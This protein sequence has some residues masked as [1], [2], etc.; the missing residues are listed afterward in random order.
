MKP[1]TLPPRW[2]HLVRLFLPAGII[3]A[4][5]FSLPVVHVYGQVATPAIEAENAAEERPDSPKLD[6]IGEK[7]KQE[8]NTSPKID[9]AKADEYELMKMF[10]D[11]LDEVQRN[12]VEPISRREL[13]EA[14]IEG[15]LAKLDVYSDYIAPEDI[16]DFRKDVESEFGGIGIQV[17]L[18]DGQ[19]TVVRPLNGTP[20][21]RAGLRSGDRIEEVNGTSTIGL[22]LDEAVKLMK[23][24]IGTSVL[25]KVRHRDGSVESLSIKR[26]NILVET[27]ISHARN[28]DGTWDFMFDK[29]DKIGY[30]RITSFSG[31]TAEE[32]R[33]ALTELQDEALRALI[34]DLRFNPGGLLTAAIEV[35]DMFL[36]EGRIVSTSGRNVEEQSWNAEKAGTFDGFPMVVLVNQFSAS[37]SEIVSACLQDN[38]RAVVIGQRTWGKGSVQKVIELEQGRSALKLTTSS[39]LRPNGKNIHRF[40]NSTEDDEWGV[41]PNPDMEVRLTPEQI[42][43]LRRFQLELSSDTGDDTQ[44]STYIDPQLERALSYLKSELLK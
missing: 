13:M 23:G 10:V 32:L 40:E 35:S 26:D 27:V 38:Q 21:K 7:I 11:A 36:S 14:A 42:A 39:Y 24:R 33:A 1:F 41:R 9:V 17:Q 18:E 44:R 8:I 29:Q 22:S 43:R 15:V 6:E 37:A 5:T 20:G 34:L 28:P 2:N 25:V 19:L 16:D 12:Y 31:H 30:L 3:T 4:V